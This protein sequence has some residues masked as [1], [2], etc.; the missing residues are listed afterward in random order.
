MGNRNRGKEFEKKFSE[1]W[2]RCFPKTFILRLK[3]DTSGYYGSG[4][5]PCDFICFPRD[6]LFMIETKSHHGNTFPF[7]DLRQYGEMLS[8]KDCANTIIGVVIWYID[9]DRVI[10]VP[11]STIIQMKLNDLK[12]ININKLDGY[13]YVEIPSKKKRVFLDSDYTV[14]VV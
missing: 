5:N 3:D 8:Y 4:K 7:S 9:H 6:K 1:D 14:L 2:K 11:L 13:E 12:S 10:F